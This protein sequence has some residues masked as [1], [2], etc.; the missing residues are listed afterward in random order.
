MVNYT[1]EEVAQAIVSLMDEV[2][3]LRRVYL[4][5]GDQ[6][7]IESIDT[8]SVRVKVLKYFLADSPNQETFEM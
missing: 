4:K 6:S 8:K 3:T 2:A 7:F 1:R 5:T